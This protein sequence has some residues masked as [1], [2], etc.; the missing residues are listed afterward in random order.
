MIIGEKVTLFF[1]EAKKSIQKGDLFRVT[2]IDP[3]S[4]EVELVAI[5]RDCLRDDERV[6]GAKKLKKGK[7]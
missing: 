4:D 7:N 2:S 1:F 5:E 3:E 6:P